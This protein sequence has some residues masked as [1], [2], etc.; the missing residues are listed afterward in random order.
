MSKTLKVQF[1]T[2]AAII[3]PK[4]K[5]KEKGHRL[6][7]RQVT[8]AMLPWDAVSGALHV[9]SRSLAV[10]GDLA[11]RRLSRVSCRFI[12]VVPDEASTRL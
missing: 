6:G 4:T 12:V 9:R 3:F 2:F 10:P 5:M 11:S 7:E 1:A 8:H